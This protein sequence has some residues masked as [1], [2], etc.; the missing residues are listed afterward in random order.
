MCVD[1]DL[2][3]D[4]SLN[5]TWGL[6][7]SEDPAGWLSKTLF[8]RRRETSRDSVLSKE[9]GNG[10]WEEGALENDRQ[11]KRAVTLMASPSN[12]YTCVG[13][14]GSSGTSSQRMTGEEVLSS[15]LLQKTLQL[16]HFQGSWVLAMTG[17]G[18][19]W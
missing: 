19:V 10:H 4:S 12:V 2:S 7:T 6:D 13:S 9:G 3:G 16:E 15:S 18:G 11:G 8:A 14:R 17:D 5:P 1:C